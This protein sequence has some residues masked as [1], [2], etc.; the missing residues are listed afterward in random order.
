MSKKWT[1]G[2]SLDENIVVAKT[3]NADYDAQKGSLNGGIDR[4]MMDRDWMDR[5]HIKDNA[6]HAVALKTETHLD[7]QYTGTHSDDGT[8]QF[9]C[10]EYDFY[11]G[12]FVVNEDSTLTVTDCKEGMGH[13]EF[14]SWYWYNRFLSP[15]MTHGINWQLLY[16]STIVATSSQT[17][18]EWGNINISADFPITGGTAIIELRFAF[19]PP[20]RKTAVFVFGVD[21][22][23]VPMMFFGGGQM[24]FIP[25]WR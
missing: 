24:L 14:T 21:V 20:N 5:A 13:V 8:Q 17:L 22:L 3:F 12:G 10:L 1:E 2:E 7:A 11:G 25:R 16:N 6:F 23:E 4:T 19:T 15:H 18:T 9:L